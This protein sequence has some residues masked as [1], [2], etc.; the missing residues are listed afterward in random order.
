MYVY[1]QYWKIFFPRFRSIQR[2]LDAIDELQV[3]QV[4]DSNEG[5]KEGKEII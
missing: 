3:A 1:V 5:L 4:S 2:Y